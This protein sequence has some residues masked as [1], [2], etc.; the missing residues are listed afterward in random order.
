MLSGCISEMECLTILFF[1]IVS[2]WENYEKLHFIQDEHHILCFLFVRGLTIILVGGL[3][4]ED[5][6]NG[7]REV[8]VL[9]HVTSF[10]GDGPKGKSTDPKQ[11]HLMNWNTNSRY[12]CSCS[13]RL[14]KKRDWRFVFSLH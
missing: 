7:L 9:L 8:P 5:Q 2:R 12:V 14:L 11:E 6:Q 13:S 1:P 4:V 10:C 3:G